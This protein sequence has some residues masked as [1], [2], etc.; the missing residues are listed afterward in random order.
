MP[1]VVEFLESNKDRKKEIRA[2]DILKNA[3]TNNIKLYQ[4]FL[5]LYEL[6]NK[7][8]FQTIYSKANNN[9]PKFMV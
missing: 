9:L 1:W 4:E 7:G 6:G 5:K 8:A 3:D 2:K